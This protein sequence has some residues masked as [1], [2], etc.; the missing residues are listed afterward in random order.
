MNL[1]VLPACLLIAQDTFPAFMA[2]MLHYPS[3]LRPAGGLADGV[4]DPDLEAPGG[5]EMRPWTVP[6]VGGQD[7]PYCAALPNL[8]RG[9]ARVAAGKD[10]K[11]ADQCNGA[12]ERLPH[13]DLLISV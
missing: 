3:S 5:Q 4:L 1:Y 13:S 6:G 10:R 2:S 8:G 7:G 11:Q 12:D 9:L